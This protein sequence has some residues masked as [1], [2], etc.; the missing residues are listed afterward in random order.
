MKTR[1]LTTLP[2]LYMCAVVGSLLGG[3]VFIGCDNSPRRAELSWVEPVRLDSGEEV[4][5]RRHVIVRQERAFGGGFASAA[6]YD[7]TSVSLEPNI[8]QF[9]AWDAPLVPIYIDKDSSTSEWIVIASSDSCDI[10]LRNGRPRPPY[11][12]FRLR[13]GAWY[14]DSIPEEFI[15]RT[16]NLFVGAQVTD[17]SGK[18]SRELRANKADFAA[19][20]KSA[21]QYKAVYSTFPDI[22]NCGSARETLPI[23]ENELDLKK[24]QK[25]AQ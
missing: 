15:G 5:V 7:T 22:E 1:Y 19:K 25:A 24:F 17:E 16:S 12:A 18:L 3:L 6:V 11:W 23:G 14:R 2:K 13:E 20:R 21:P 4:Y 8:P 9:P 10:W